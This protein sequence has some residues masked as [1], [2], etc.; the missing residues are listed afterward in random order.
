MTSYSNSTRS[1]SFIA[2]G[3][4]SVIYAIDENHVVKIRPSSG[5]FECQ[6]YDIE[7]R[8]YQRIGHHKHVARCEVT[9]EGLRLER[10]TGL[11]SMLQSANGPTIPLTTKFRWAQE[12]AQGLSYIH[13]K[14]IVHADVGCHNIIV[15]SSRHIKFIDFAGSSID[16]AASLVCYELCSFQPGN[17]IGISTDIFASGSMLFEL[18]T[19]RVPYHELEGTLEMGKLVEVVEQLFSQHI[20]PSVESLAF[21]PVISGCWNGKYMSMDEVR[22]DLEC[23]KS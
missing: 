4:V 3:S 19:G 7:V 17:D 20:F 6:A 9:D 8:S 23:S 12:A 10:G 18:E 16:G 13:S 22:R 14:G 1:R 2:S 11:R 21:G 5:D 15:D